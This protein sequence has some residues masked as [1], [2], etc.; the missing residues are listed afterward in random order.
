MNLDLKTKTLN[1]LIELVNSKKFDEIP[2][3]S[4][5]EITINL[6]FILVILHQD[7][8]LFRAI[9]YPEKPLNVNK[10][11]YPPIE[12]AKKNRASDEGEQ[13][14]YC[15]DSKITCLY[16]IN[17]D[18]NDK[19]VIGE[20]NTQ[21]HLFTNSIGFTKSNLDY[22]GTDQYRFTE[23]FKAS[24]HPKFFAPD[25]YSLIEKIGYLFCQENFEENSNY[26]AFTIA[27]AKAL[28]NGRIINTERQIDGI[29]Y[30]TI[31]NNGIDNNLALFPNVINNK[32]I[33]LDRVEY[34]E[35]INNEE[36][37]LLD[38]ADSI[39]ADGSINWIS[40]DRKYI[41][42]VKNQ[43]YV[44]VYENGDYVCYDFQG[45]IINPI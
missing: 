32:A 34:I 36:Y 26:Y 16:E 2:I 18:K 29:I 20:W 5:N 38:F 17:A 40:L 23:E 3:E 14:F 45:N 25:N 19:I 28:Y 27:I 22:L 35:M 4:V 13:L 24:F 7:Y 6:A 8:S 37:I 30:P 12:K 1:Y 43:E 11:V 15:S 42:S 21:D 33:A 39:K 41:F 9:K 44:F 31:R 10:L